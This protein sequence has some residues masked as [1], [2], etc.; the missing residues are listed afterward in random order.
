MLTTRPPKPSSICKLIIKYKY[1]RYIHEIRQES[2]ARYF[3][4]LDIMLS[5]IKKLYFYR[6]LISELCA[7][8]NNIK[9]YS[10]AI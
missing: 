9:L 7:Q 10:E 6:I 4:E 1:E 8:N 2:D 3:S 5:K